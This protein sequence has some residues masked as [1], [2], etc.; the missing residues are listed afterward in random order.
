MPVLLKLGII[1]CKHV[2]KVNS[3][4]IIC[5]FSGYLI[6]VPSVIVRNS[7]TPVC[8]TFHHIPY[9]VT[10]TF[11]LRALRRQTTHTQQERFSRGEYLSDHTHTT[12]EVL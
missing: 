1:H 12:G 9:D 11:T 10:V 2:D 8:A 7:S 5:I 3:F 6:S 4:P